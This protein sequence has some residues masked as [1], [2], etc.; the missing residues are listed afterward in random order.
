MF[1]PYCWAI[2]RSNRENILKE[3]SGI[4]HNNACELST[5]V[6]LLQ[7]VVVI[8]KVMAMYLVLSSNH[9]AITLEM[10][11]TYCNNAT[12]VGSSHALLC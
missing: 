3:I 9:M 6:S 1:R 8:S 5:R 12:L 2:I 7:Y 11:T 10:T 4:Q